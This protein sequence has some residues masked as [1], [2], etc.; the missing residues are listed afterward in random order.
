[1]ESNPCMS[2]SRFSVVDLDM[3]VNKLTGP[4]YTLVTN[5][6]K[7][8]T[9]NTQPHISLECKKMVWC[10]FTTSSP[11]CKVSSEIGSKVHPISKGT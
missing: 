2:D 6:A 4:R 9:I 11:S 8:M 3:Q 5:I 1:M 10:L 7:H